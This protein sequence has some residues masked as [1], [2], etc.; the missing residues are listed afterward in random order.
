M[1]RE[2]RNARGSQR[3]RDVLLEAIYELARI[4]CCRLNGR[5]APKFR[6]A[7]EALE[8]FDAAEAAPVQGE[9]AQV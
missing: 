1:I 7:V 2:R 4:E 9:L 5:L 6:E 3:R 8:A